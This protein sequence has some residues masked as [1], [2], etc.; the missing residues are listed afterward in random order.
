MEQGPTRVLLKHRRSRLSLLKVLA[1]DN[2]LRR[3]DTHT[4]L[5]QLCQKR[6]LLLCLQVIRHACW[7]TVSLERCI[8]KH[9]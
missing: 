3:L 2:K 4:H 7:F 6:H 8:S 5:D 9:I 1:V